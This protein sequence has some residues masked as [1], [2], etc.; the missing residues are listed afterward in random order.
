[1]IEEW[2]SAVQ[3]CVSRADGCDSYIA[4]TIEGVPLEACVSV[5]RASANAAL[6]ALLGALATFGFEGKVLVEDGTYLAPQ[7]YEVEAGKAS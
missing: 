1:M 2:R 6:D 5:E 3:V 4:K 7:T